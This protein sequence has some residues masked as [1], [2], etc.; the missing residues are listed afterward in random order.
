MP[1]AQLTAPLTTPAG[2]L[3]GCVDSPGDSLTWGQSM[4]HQ[5]VKYHHPWKEKDLVGCTCQDP[6]GLIHIFSLM[7]CSAK[8]Y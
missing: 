3:Q 4:E 6:K 2:D 5:R 7:K 8:I 1:K